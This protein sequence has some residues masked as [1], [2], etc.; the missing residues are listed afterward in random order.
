MGFFAILNAYSLRTCVSIAIVDMSN[1]RKPEINA[2]DRCT[3]DIGAKR[4]SH[5]LL[6]SVT[7]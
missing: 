6:L 7:Q 3:Y 5:K 2:T 1:Y 4:N